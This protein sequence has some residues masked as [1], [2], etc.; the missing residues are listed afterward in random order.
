MQWMV[1][2]MLN[3][4]CPCTY[5]HLHCIYMYM[6]TH[7]MHVWYNM[8]LCTVCLCAQLLAVLLSLFTSI[9]LFVVSCYS[10]IVSG[11]GGHWTVRLSRGQLELGCSSP[12]HKLPPSTGPLSISAPRGPG[13]N[14]C[15]TTS[16][17]E[18][19]TRR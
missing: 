17:T 7:D 1:S 18:S 2:G 14:P 12:C 3:V 11:L 4:Y 8:F 5:N 13:D 9:L 15:T 19:N 16:R 10:Y 6:Y